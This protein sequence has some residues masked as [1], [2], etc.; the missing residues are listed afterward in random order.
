MSTPTA[1][2]SHYHTPRLYETILEKLQEQGL[3][4]DTVT[5]KSISGVDEFH[6]RGAEV[7]IELA[8]KIDIRGSSV[9]DVGCGI[10]GP[11]R[12]LADIYACQVTGIDLNE[13]YIRTAALLSELVGLSEQTSFLRGN[14][15]ALPFED[16]SFEVVWTQHVQ[17]NIQDKMAFYK[18]IH[19]VLKKGGSF[20]YYDIFKRGASSISYPVPWADDVSIS[21]L[22]PP[23]EMTLILQNLGF[24]ALQTLDQTE[25]GIAFFEK[26]MARIQEVGPPKIGINLL[27]GDKTPVKIGNLLN[28]LKDG[29]LQL[30][31]GVYLKE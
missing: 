19:R 8:E 10:G 9:L 4:L 25:K 23:E 13:E 24:R 31:S 29:K 14:A 3:D 2:Q 26:L 1:I 12:M 28:G 7:S 21:F 30:Q 6:V 11:C 18:E 17:M 15:T 22:F 27:M 20:L 16:E 5:R